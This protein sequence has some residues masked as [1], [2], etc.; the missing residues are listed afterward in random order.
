M[1]DSLTPA[2]SRVYDLIAQQVRDLGVPPTVREMAR[3][4]NVAIGTVQD[5]L[6]A[7]DR[8]GAIK[9]IKDRARGATVVGLREM[10]VRLPVLGHVPAGSPR[11]AIAQA[12]EFVSLS[13]D[14]TR[15]AHFALRARGDS[16]EPKIEDGDL[17]LVRVQSDAVDG[18]VV[19]A[20]FEEDAETTVKRFRKKQH[21]VFLQAD[22]PRYGPFHRPFKVT[23]KVTGLIRTRIA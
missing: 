14:L 15:G 22:N 5:H 12:D 23:G 1:S 4:L 8:K 11:E 9:K 7:L 6:A 3:Q 20:Q 19:I 21:R 10:G 16:M 2:Q 18:D 13:D 17:L